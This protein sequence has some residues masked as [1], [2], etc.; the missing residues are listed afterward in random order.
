MDKLYSY[1][2]G[3]ETKQQL[4]SQRTKILAHQASLAHNKAGLVFSEAQKTQLENLT[5]QQVAH[6]ISTME[7]IFNTAYYLVKNDRPFTDHEDLIQLQK[8]NGLNVGITLHSRYSATEIIKHIA[9]EF[10]K[11]LISKL[12]VENRKISV[13]TDESTTLDKQSTLIIYIKTFLDEKGKQYFLI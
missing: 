7:K 12:T 4:K 13:L 1:L 11:K 6:C 9:L 10:K 8:K 5:L 2:N 3:T